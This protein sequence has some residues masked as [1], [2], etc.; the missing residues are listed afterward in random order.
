MLILRDVFAFSAAEVAATIGSTVPA[1][2]SALQRARRTLEERLPDRSQQET[3]RALGDERVREVVE[4]FVDAFEGAEVDTILGLLSD[5]ATFAMPPF[6]E[7]SRGRD[8]V[9]DSWL[10][11]TGA[12]G[13]L[14]YAATSANGQ[15][16]LGTYRT[17]PEDPNR[18]IPIALDV[19]AL[20]PDGTIGQVVVFRQ[21]EIF[22]R[23]G[24]PPALPA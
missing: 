3:L 20:R 12:A 4:R 21:T 8:A 15:P 19:I 7:W 18:Y 23:F 1:V 16:A 17:D 5:D 22:D 13:E 14:R 24:L 6:D 10:M 11:P 9:G 2:N